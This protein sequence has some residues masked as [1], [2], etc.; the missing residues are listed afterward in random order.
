MP[1]PRYIKPH[2]DANHKPD[3]PVSHN[4][5]PV[6]QTSWWCGLEEI[7]ASDRLMTTPDVQNWELFY[8]TSDD[9][10]P[11]MIAL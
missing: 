11:P 1:F 2:N 3:N 5:S 10:A 6:I 7:P 9:V 8:I 4:T